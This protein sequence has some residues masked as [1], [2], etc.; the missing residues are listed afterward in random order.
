MLK[1]K[2]LL[3]RNYDPLNLIE[4]SREN[5]RSDYSYLSGVNKNIKI[6]PVLKSNAYGHGISLV[7]KIFD[8]FNPPFICVDSLYEAYE[9]LKIS[10]K[11]QILI[12]G[13]I[14]PKSLNTKKLP[15]SYA[16]YN[17]ELIDAIAKYQPHAKI[18]IFV[19]TGMHREGVRIEDLPKFLTLVKSKKLGI[20]GLMSH[21]AMGDDIKNEDTRKQV[22]TF[23]K[24]R[25]I[26][27]EYRINPKWIHIANS[28]GL[29][30]SREYR[31]RLGN[32]ARVGKSSYG[33]DPR[34]VNQDLKPALTLKTHIAQ[35]KN[36]KKGEKTGYDFS[37]IAKKD[38][39][40]AIIPIGYFEGVDRRLSNKGYV[41]I[42]GKYCKIIGRVSMNITIIDVSNIKNLKVGK[43]VIVYSNDPT[44]KNS[45]QNSAKICNT[46]P[47]ELLVHLGS[48]TKRIIKD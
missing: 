16:V 29:L 20:E 36:L 35:V 5:L 42:R 21:F 25:Q 3:G 23:T 47:Y 45:I 19:D 40:I 31:N 18:H 14:S 24:A 2:S 26:L 9:L 38:M 44:A 13:F 46:I 37:F 8:S 27:K 4:I 22:E 43:E 1:I 39:K 15:F 7:G 28:A 41:L 30:N 6:S 34:K 12:M 32:M 17:K 48:S 10:V 33:I 11:T